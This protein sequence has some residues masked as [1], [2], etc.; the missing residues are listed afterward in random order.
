M[1]K[2]R[3][4]NRNIRPIGAFYILFPSLLGLFFTPGLYS[5]CLRQIFC[6]PVF[7]STQEQ[8]SF[9]HSDS[10]CL[11]LF[12]QLFDKTARKFARPYFSSFFDNRLSQ[13]TGWLYWP[14]RQQTSNLL[15]LWFVMVPNHRDA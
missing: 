5:L 10:L 7:S 12:M 15:S 9:F 8:N 6:T 2:F 11:F 13:L 1:Q 14:Y 4:N 3:L